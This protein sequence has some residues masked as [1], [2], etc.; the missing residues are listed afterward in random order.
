MAVN[1]LLSDTSG[2]R[3][4]ARPKQVLQGDDDPTWQSQRFDLRDG[5]VDR[6]RDL[7]ERHM[8]LAWIPA[9]HALA[10]GVDANIEPSGQDPG[11]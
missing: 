8:N 5:A 3:R 6:I 7:A 9:L 10:M 4:G 1:A 2:G 11:A